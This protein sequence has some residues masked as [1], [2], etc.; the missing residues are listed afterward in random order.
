MRVIGPDELLP[1]GRPPTQTEVGEAWAQ[2]HRDLRA[3]LADPAIRRVF[4][5]VG[6]PGSGKS[7]WCRAQPEMPQAVAFDAVMSQRPR[8]SALAMR[9]RATGRDA[10]A[11]VMQT[12]IAIAMERNAAR[13]P[14]RRVPETA[15]TRAAVALRSEPPCE[16]E[17]WSDI[18][19]VS[20][21]QDARTSASW[22]ERRGERFFR[23]RTETDA[24]V[25]P[26]HERLHGRIF[27]W[28]EGANGI[29]PGSERS[30]PHDHNCRCWAEAVDD[31]DVV[32]AR[33]GLRARPLTIPKWA[34]ARPRRA[35]R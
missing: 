18:W 10:I 4:V 24:S 25:R 7:T 30:K 17:G 33:G 12:P 2:A 16:A 3:A 15:I 23:W 29:W 19:L 26:E 13:P 35:R 8:R 27:S 34:R 20:R 28:E 22:A 11:V 21:R 31:E 14:A 5:L 6:I 32:A 1:E 9:I